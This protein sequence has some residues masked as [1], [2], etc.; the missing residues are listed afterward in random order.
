MDTLKVAVA[1]V[2]DLLDRQLALVVDARY[3]NG[4]PPGLVR[5]DE[6]GA[7]LHHGFKGVQICCSAVVAEALQAS[8]PST[9]FSR[10]TESHNQ[11][12]VSMATIAARGAATVIDLVGEA[13]ALHLAALAQAAD[14]RGP[15]LLAPG[16]RAVHD[17][18]RAHTGPLTDDR[19][20]D[21]EIA[22]LVAALRERAVTHALENIGD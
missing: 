5:S 1:S 15:H 17:V 12:K 11:D 4:L 13:T 7:G 16:T 19:R 6:A 2:G 8:T 21:R 10:S 14:L 9:V 3:S 18:V 22:K 20:L